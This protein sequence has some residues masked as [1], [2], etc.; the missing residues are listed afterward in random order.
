[1]LT[2]G[3]RLDRITF[4]QYGSTRLSATDPDVVAGRAIASTLKF[5]P[6][7]EDTTRFKPVTSTL[8]G[9]LHATRAF[10][11]FYNHANNN[12]Q[13]PFNA[14]VLPDETLPPPFDG[15]SDDSLLRMLAGFVT[16]T[17]GRIFFDELL[18]IG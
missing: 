16:P 10:S 18:N 14:R 7:I 13:P 6:Q 12:S 3:V 1:M 2:A 9:V 17:S 8:G 4:D 15:L 5:T 11:I